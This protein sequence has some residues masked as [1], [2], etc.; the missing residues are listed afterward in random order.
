M[1]PLYISSV[2]CA[3]LM[4]AASWGDV[5]RAAVASPPAAGGEH[6]LCATGRLASDA[7]LWGTEAVRSCF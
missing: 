1:L 5:E 7:Q 6:G 4:T 3:P 2:G